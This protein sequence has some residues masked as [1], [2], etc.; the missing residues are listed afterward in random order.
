MFLNNE[1]IEICSTCIKLNELSGLQ[2]I[3]YLEYITG[4]QK[5][6]KEWENLPDEDRLPKAVRVNVEVNAWLISRSLW[7]NDRSKSVDT[8]RDEVM[9]QWSADSIAS[10][11]NN[12]LRLSGLLTD[13]DEPL[14]T[15]SDH[16]A[17]AYEPYP[18]PEYS[19]GKP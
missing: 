10:A 4:V 6:I 14:T 2:R 5:L 8:L 13:S 11:G 19:E 1:E 12:V 16:T 18:E 9:Q 7:H 17:R 15:N 3:E